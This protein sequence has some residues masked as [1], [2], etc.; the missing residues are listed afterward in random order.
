M[1]MLFGLNTS[2]KYELKQPLKTFF[3][4]SIYHPDGW[5]L[6][7]YRDK[8]TGHEIIRGTE[9]A[10]DSKLLQCLF[11]TS[12]EGKI[13]IGHIRKKTQGN[14]CISNTHPFNIPLKE[15]DWILAHNGSVQLDK[16]YAPFK[17]HGNTDSEKVLC[18]IVNNL[19]DCPDTQKATIHNIEKSIVE[20]SAFGKLNLL[21][22]DGNIMIVHTNM[23]STLYYSKIKYGYVFCTKTMNFTNNWRPVPLNT[24]LVYKDGDLIYEGKK[25]TNTYFHQSKL[26]EV[27]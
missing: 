3:G 12:I 7:T 23:A 6:C 15:K 9:P 2:K 18:H 22:T 14:V 27:I 19:I 11:N 13:V 16:A 21:L 8:G 5:G 17:P 10:K 4:Q 25:H 24:V 1:C 20:I 26:D